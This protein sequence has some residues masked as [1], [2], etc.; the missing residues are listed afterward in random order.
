M[1]TR[2]SRLALSAGA[3]AVSLMLLSA[4]PAG[5]AGHPSQSLGQAG[6]DTT[7]FMMGPIAS[8]Y[9]HST[10]NTNHDIITEIPPVNQAPFPASVTVPADKVHPAMTWDSS[11]PAATPPNGSSAGITAL[12]NDKTGLIAFGR[13]SRGQNPGET[14]KIQFW[15]YALGA[16]DPVTFP[17]TDAPKVGL[18]Q[19]Q[20]IGIYTCDP[21]TGQPFFSNWSQVGGTG[22]LIIR[23]APQAGSGTL[24]FFQTKWLN[25]ASVDQNCDSSHLATRLEEHDARGVVSATFANSIYIYDWA[26]YNAQQK[27]FEQNLTNSAALIPAGPNSS[28]LKVPT[29]AN[30]NETKTRFFG[31]RYVY[32]VMEKSA[33]PKSDTDQINDITRLIGVRNTAQGGAQ[34]ICSGKAKADIIKAGFVPLAKFATGGIGLGSSF[35]RLNP[36]PL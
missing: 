16:V 28:S 26:R 32:N 8:H 10:A 25:G 18:T 15:A 17:G 7:Y 29:A 14:A 2:M 20:I 36:T 6:S 33:H 31:T 35:C 1:R 5:A 13:S 21:K 34:Y 27:G 12:Q 23:Y 24:S 22:G 19:A 4:G 11:S 9:Q 30:V 3:A